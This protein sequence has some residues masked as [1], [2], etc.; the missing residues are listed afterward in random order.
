MK[1][2]IIILLITAC[3]A[4]GANPEGYK[5]ET[6]TTPQDVRFHI[7]GLDIDKSGKIYCATRF[8]DVWILENGKWTRFAKGLQEPCGLVVDKDGSVIV[9]QKPEMTRLVDSDKDGVAD[10]YLNLAN[11]WEF[12][13]NYH[14][15][16]FG[17]VIDNDGNYIGTLNL[18]AGPKVPG[19]KLS[20]MSTEGGYRGWAYRVSTEGK[21]TPFAWGLRSPAGI[22]KNNLGELFFTDNQGD[23][24]ATST[25]NH[26][27][28]NK[29]YGHPISLL[30]KP[31]YSME[32]LKK[33]SDEEF[34]K[35]RTLPV[36]WIPQEEIA[37]S[38]GNPE[39]NATKG[40]FGPF[41]NQFFIGDQTRSNI[42]R[43][44]LQKVGGRYQGCVINFMSGL[45]CGNIRL[46]F[47]KEGTLWAGQTNR[48]WASRGARP[49]GLQK[50]V[51]DG[52]TIP[53]EIQDVKLT[54]D[55]FKITFTKEIDPQSVKIENI[56]ISHWWY[57]YSRVYGSPKVDLTDQKINS[58]HLS[59]DGKSV[60]VKL[61]LLKEKVYCLDVSKFLN[62][63][64]QSVQNTKAYY[65]LI[66]LIK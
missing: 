61:P 58:A 47:D 57:N 54:K 46:K 30:D 20:A 24:V 11:A 19:L 33:M 13:N 4:F 49:Y 7:A 45:Q 27:E 56:A 5:I 21:F 25:L 59:E 63:N 26:L 36:V 1:Q 50:V 18:A 51:W 43:A 66:N 29:F 35:M 38:P 10:L 39:W 42:F 40:K 37:N 62:K 17:G 52:K 65:T 34:G 60:I 53:F 31:E 15:F 6:V 64:G 14:E 44:S 2:L 9:T 3:Y 16:N 22:G 48:G 32:K 8:G 28:D 12:H 55:G 41:D 23:Y